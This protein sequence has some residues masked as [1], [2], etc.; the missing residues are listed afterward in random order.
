VLAVTPDPAAGRRMN[1]LWGT[2]PVTAE[3]T[4]LEQAPALARRLV[5][6]LGLAEE[7]HYILMVT[8][9]RTAPEA[10]EP[11]VTVLRM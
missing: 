3:A 4:E 1:L 9:F 8:G 7:G 11:A 6:G 5:R 10:S 2:V